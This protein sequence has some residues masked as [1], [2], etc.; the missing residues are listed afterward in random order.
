[1]AEEFV[2]SERLGSFDLPVGSVLKVEGKKVLYRD[3][4]KQRHIFTKGDYSAIGCDDVV[5]NY[6]LQTGGIDEVWFRLKDT[7]EILSVGFEK[8]LNATPKNMAGRK[9]RFV[10]V[11][12][13][14]TV[15]GVKSLSRPVERVVIDLSK[16]RG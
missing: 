1:M 13:F 8:Y 9:Q 4:E 3:I 11:G 12:A 6:L 10:N 2:L 5:I 15:E 7:G 16:K 14:R